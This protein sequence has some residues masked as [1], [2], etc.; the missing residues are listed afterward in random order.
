MDDSANGSYIRGNIWTAEL[1]DAGSLQLGRVA[2]PQATDL[3]L[4]PRLHVSGNGKVGIGTIRPQALLHVEGGQDHEWGMILSSTGGSASGLKINHGWHGHG[5][6]PIFQA[7]ARDGNTE[8]PRFVIYANGNI[9]IGT[10]TPEAKLHVVGTVLA[11][12]VV[13]PNADCAEEFNVD[14][15]QALEP[16]TVMVIGEEET[17]HPCTD[18]YDK[19]VAGV[20]SGGGDCRPGVVLG[21]QPSPHTRLPLALTGKVYCKVDAQSSPIEVGDL[22]TTSSTPGHAMKALDPLKGFGAVIGK[23]LRP[24]REGQGLIPILIVLQ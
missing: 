2:D 21:R 5:F 6:I 4:I 19:R 24:L 12:D 23:A 9:G 13:L 14:A 10:T 17:L 16:G 1:Q 11:E 20:L 3:T 22:L 18:A 15:S 8:V 7:N